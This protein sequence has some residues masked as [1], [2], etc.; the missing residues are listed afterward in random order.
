MHVNPI[1]I[2]EELYFHSLV[3]ELIHAVFRHISY[4]ILI[5]L[6]MIVIP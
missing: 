5:K 6:L 2:V 3:L 4:S 1:I